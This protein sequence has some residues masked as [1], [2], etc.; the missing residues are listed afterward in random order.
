M[1][2]IDP[3]AVAVRPS[4]KF[5]LKLHEIAPEDIEPNGDRYIVEEIDIDEKVLLGKILVVTQQ[6]AKNDRS[7]SSDPTIENRGVIAAVIIKAG[8]GHLLGLSDFPPMG[9]PE[10]TLK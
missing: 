5:Q 9:V 6:V 8:N 4:D 10:R 1:A 7:P 2:H 3:L